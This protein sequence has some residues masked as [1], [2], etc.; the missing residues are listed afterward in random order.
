MGSLAA[1]SRSRFGPTSSREAR[2]ASPTTEGA[3]GASGTGGVV[4]EGG[5]G[6]LPGGAGGAGSGGGAPP[7][8]SCGD[9]A[10]AEAPGDGC[11]PACEL[12]P[13]FTCA[14]TPSVC[15]PIEPVVTKTGLSASPSDDAY[16][17]SLGSMVW[18]H[19][20]V[21]TSFPTVARVKVRVGVAH[22][23]VGQV[24]LKLVALTGDV[25]TL[26]NR[27]GLSERVD[28][29]SG[30]GGDSSNLTASVPVV[31]ADDAPCDARRWAGGSAPSTRCARTTDAVRFGPTPNLRQTMGWRVSWGSR[32]AARGRCASATPARCTWASSDKWSLRCWRGETRTRPGE[33][34]GA[35]FGF[36]GRSA[37]DLSLEPLSEALK[38][39]PICRHHKQSGAWRAKHA[40]DLVSTCL[41]AGLLAPAVAAAF[42]HLDEKTDV[43][44]LALLCAFFLAREPWDVVLDCSRERA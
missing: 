40:L 33:S 37:A 10:L 30:G 42:A 13:G 38:G 27:P 14:G 4:A 34:E 36:V 41:A 43:P 21:Q 20:E 12:E 31:F 17:G 25:A 2:E 22:R 35:R 15:A 32:R 18:V 16:D 7:P 1:C 5:A 24:V 9:G 28:D 29:G 8:S 39:V 23:F 44:T 6:G 11:S 3:G 19:L 26:L